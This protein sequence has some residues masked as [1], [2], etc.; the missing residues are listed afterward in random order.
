MPSLRI[1]SSTKAILRLQERQTKLNVKQAKIDAEWVNLDT[2][3]VK[4]Q[5]KIDAKFEKQVNKELARKKRKFA[6]LIARVL[7]MKTMPMHAHVSGDMLLN[8]LL[9]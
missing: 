3:T 9:I 8:S 4:K 1:S 5:A 2:K 7:K 6:S